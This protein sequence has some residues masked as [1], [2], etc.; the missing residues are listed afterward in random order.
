M[1]EL[2]EQEMQLNQVDVPENLLL[3]LQKSNLVGSR[4]EPSSSDNGG[5]MTKKELML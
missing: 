1:I 2:N 4:M 5:K 3:P